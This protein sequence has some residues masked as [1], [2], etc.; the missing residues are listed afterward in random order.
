MLDTDSNTSNRGEK[1]DQTRLHRRAR[2]DVEILRALAQ[3]IAQLLRR[4]HAHCR[5][6]HSS[7]PFYR[8]VNE[9]RN[10]RFASV[11]EQRACGSFFLFP[12]L[13]SS[14]SSSILLYSL[15]R[16]K[17][18]PCSCVACSCV[19]KV[20]KERMGFENWKEKLELATDH[21]DNWKY[22]SFLHMDGNLFSISLRRSLVL[23]LF[24]IQSCQQFFNLYNIEYICLITS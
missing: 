9:T 4:I 23:W 16:E 15:R 8:E 22:F 11:R 10:D 21:F 6:I 19:T 24:M 18:Y 20:S 13:V 2:L 3:I 7:F 5:V 1:L 12:Y 17:L 14:Y